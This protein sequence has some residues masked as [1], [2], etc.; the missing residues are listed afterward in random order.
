VLGKV[1]IRW[2]DGVLCYEDYTAMGLIL[3]L[4][5]RR[6]R[7]PADVAVAG[8]D[9]LPIGSSFSMG[10]TTYA[11][12]LE[13]LCR[14]ALRT[15]RTRLQEPGQQPVKVVVPGKLIIRESTVGAGSS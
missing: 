2:A 3:E 5:T 14:Q 10:V 11:L 6:I 4:L 7:V 1:R 15:M 13:D 8:F 12:A 9:N